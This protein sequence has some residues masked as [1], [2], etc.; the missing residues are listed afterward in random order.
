MTDLCC[1]ACKKKNLYCCIQ[2]DRLQDRKS[3]LARSKSTHNLGDD[4]DEED[5]IAA[6]SPAAYLANRYGSDL[7]RSRS[8]HAIK[9]RE[10]SPDRPASSG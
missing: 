4:D 2:A 10:P 7:S 5:V 6:N 3:R 1:L 9:S 8:S